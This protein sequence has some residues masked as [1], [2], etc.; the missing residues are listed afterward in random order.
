MW[1]RRGVPKPLPGRVA[2]GGG[3]HHRGGGGAHEWE[4]QVGLPLYPVKC[5]G[6]EDASIDITQGS[7]KSKAI[8]EL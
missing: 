5:L 8:H 4:A 2:D 1:G 6:G 7:L 3:E